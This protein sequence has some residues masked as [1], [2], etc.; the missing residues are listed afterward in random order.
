MSYNIS[1]YLSIRIYLFIFFLFCKLVWQSW[2]KACPYTF[3]NGF[4]IP[5]ATDW[6]KFYYFRYF[7]FSTIIGGWE[8]DNHGK[9]GS[10]KSL[11]FL[12]MTFS[13]PPWLLNEP[14]W[15]YLKNIGLLTF[16]YFSTICFSR[17]F[18]SNW[19]SIC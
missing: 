19:L 2:L 10:F 3:L 12:M 14:N 18:N 5:V 9:L 4:P 17:Q 1:T 7:Y 11:S 15:K 13:Q 8:K 6:T 16:S